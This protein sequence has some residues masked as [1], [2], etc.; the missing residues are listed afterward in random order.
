MGAS[1]STAKP[2]RSRARPRSPLSVSI[3]EPPSRHAIAALT[4]RHQRIAD[5]TN[6]FPGLLF[7]LANEFATSAKRDAAIS[8]IEAGRPLRGIADDLGLPFWLRKM[9]AWTFT[10][11]L[12]QL[13]SSPAHANR[14]IACLPDDHRTTARMW[15]WAVHYSTCTCGPDF[16]VWIAEQI[17]RHPNRFRGPTGRM[18]LRHL[19]AW[20]W[21]ADQPNAPGFH[22]LHRPWS[23]ELGLRRALEEATKWR[24]RI[25][26]ARTLKPRGTHAGW[27]KPGHAAGFDFV[28]LTGI[29][30]FIAESEAMD[31]CLDQF[32][33][34]LR[35]RESQVFSIR[36]RGRSVAN[37]EVGRH[38]NETSMPAILQL[39]GARNRRASS[40]L[41]Q[42]AYLWLGSQKLSPRRTSLK[43]TTTPRARR[44]FERYF[45]LPY[46]KALTNSGLPT[47]MRDEILLTFDLDP[48]SLGLNKPARKLPEQKRPAR[49]QRGPISAKTSRKA[50]TGLE[51]KTHKSDQSTPA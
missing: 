20:A 6:T 28:E 34:Q 13:P 23:R 47:E 15:L 29:E 7:A 18:A 4:R 22:Y 32:A 11:P 39:R 10:F 30:D 27:L 31:N 36:E 44:T 24:A 49:V 3:F 40:R 37:I 16:S 38:D 17:A 46:L 41:W 26:L 1:P 51:P 42:A 35:T 19:S 50:G 45:W 9:P 48:V 25:D 43:R 14:L 5:L 12:H 2:N 33:P 8:A 21:H